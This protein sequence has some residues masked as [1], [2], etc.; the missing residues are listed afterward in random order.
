[1]SEQMKA[2]T[3]R[4][5]YG[6]LLTAAL[7]FLTTYQLGRGGAYQLEDAAI[8]AGTT[9]LGYLIA[10]GMAE[11]WIDTARQASGRVSKADVGQ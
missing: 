1:M 4:A 9:L 11:G 8:A 3:I 5:L 10:R 6:A 7:T 2:A